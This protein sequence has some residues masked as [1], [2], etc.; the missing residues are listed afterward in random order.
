MSEPTEMSAGY[1]LH[2]CAT[3]G[4]TLAFARETYCRPHELRDCVMVLARQIRDLTE[5]L[6][7]DPGDE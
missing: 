5:D 3:C 2:L 4:D 6:Y 7:P 1:K